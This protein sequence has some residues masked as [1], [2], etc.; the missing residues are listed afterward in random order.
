MKD[1]RGRAIF[2]GYFASIFAPVA[3]SINES[4]KS[5][6]TLSGKN[7]DSR[8]M[9]APKNTTKEITMIELLPDFLIE[10]TSEKFCR[11]LYPSYRRKSLLDPKTNAVANVAAKLMK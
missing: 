10:L 1:K 7:A 11:V 2:K 6:A 8:F 9:I 5:H 3:I 4:I